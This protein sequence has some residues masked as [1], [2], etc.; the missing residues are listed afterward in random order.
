[1]LAV[2]RTLR[3]APPTPIEAPELRGREWWFVAG[4]ALTL[5]FL[6]ALEPPLGGLG[7]LWP[8]VNP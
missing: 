5:V 1:M 2:Y 3:G 6:A 7:G 8:V 4:I